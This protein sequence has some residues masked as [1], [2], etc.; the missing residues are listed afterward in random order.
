MGR[1]DGMNKTYEEH[2]L[3]SGRYLKFEDGDKH[4]VAFLG[5]PHIRAVYW[6][7]ATY[8]PWTDGCGKEKTLKTSMNVAVLEN[9]NG[10]YQIKAVKVLENSKTFYK[11]VSKMDTKYGVDNQVFEIERTG[12]KAKD[13]SYTVLPE[14]TITPALRAQLDALDLYDLTSDGGEDADDKKGGGPKKPEPAAILTQTDGDALIARLKALKATLGDAQG[15]QMM[16]DFL[17]TFSIAKIRD[18]PAG[19]LSVAQ[20]W[21]TQEE[22]NARHAANDGDVPGD[23]FA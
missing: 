14:A 13:T 21:V 8:H 19:S 20:T 11:Q 6:D 15:G 9:R 10:V 4:L 12:T 16:N 2:D 1:F 3:Q 23:P 22:E 5:E 17:A 7:G 18:L